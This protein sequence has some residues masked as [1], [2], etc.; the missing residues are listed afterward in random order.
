LSFAPSTQALLV[1]SRS[2]PPSNS[3]SQCLVSLCC[4]REVD[5]L[6]GD[7]SRPSGATLI[8]INP[9]KALLLYIVA[10]SHFRQIFLQRMTRSFPRLSFPSGAGQQRVHQI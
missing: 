2:A 10:C 9:G 6:A 7:D 4:E 5:G 1:C 8:R 3:S